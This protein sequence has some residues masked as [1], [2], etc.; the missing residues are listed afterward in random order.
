MDI[1][2]N[3]KEKGIISA[4]IVDDDWELNFQESALQKAGVDSTLFLK[5]EDD[6]DP[7]TI[8]LINLLEKH[9]CLSTS[10]QN[11][12]DALFDERLLNLLPKIYVEGIVELAKSRNYELKGK[13]EVIK[14]CLIELGL[15][16]ESI[17]CVA[18]IEEAKKQIANKYPTLFIIDL[19]LEEGNQDLSLNLIKKLLEEIPN[20]LEPQFILMSYAKD[21]LTQ[22]FRKFH[23]E[24]H[25]SSSRS[26]VRSL[27]VEMKPKS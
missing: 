23:K 27:G 12:V 22:L 7:A 13:L 5:L 24:L 8:D 26:Y 1:E 17:I 16:S 4:L 6:D 10:L 20:G 2:F 15:E 21:D 11:K 9:K 14:Q 25:I 19:Y 18:T 3:I